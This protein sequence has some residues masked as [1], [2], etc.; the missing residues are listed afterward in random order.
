ML[1]RLEF[2]GWLVKS[3]P[4]G[5]P[6]VGCGLGVAHSHCLF[7]SPCGPGPKRPILL[8]IDVPEHIDGNGRGCA[9]A[10]T[11]NAFRLVLRLGPAPC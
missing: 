7:T 10:L 5:R 2:T 3:A 1:S 4:T 8:A 9:V 6:L 11:L